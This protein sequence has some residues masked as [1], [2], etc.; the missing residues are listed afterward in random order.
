M[1]LPW[2]KY[3]LYNVYGTKSHTEKY[4]L[5]TTEALSESMLLLMS[6]S[7]GHDISLSPYSVL[8]AEQKI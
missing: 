8:G 3:I 7:W 1:K 2:T 6:A 5:I 4:I